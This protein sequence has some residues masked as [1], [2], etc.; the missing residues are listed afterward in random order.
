MDREE[1]LKIIERAAREGQTQL[2]LSE[3]AITSLPV[4]IGKL[5]ELTGL[6]LA[7]NQLT[8]L[9]SEIGQLTNLEV[10]SLHGNQLASVPVELAKLTKLK[11]LDLGGNRLTSIPLEIGQ[12]KNLTRLWLQDNPLESPPPEVVEQGAKAVLAYLRE[13]AEEK[14]ALNEAKML[15]VGQG[16]VGKTS[17]AKRLIEGSYNPQEMMT[18]GIKIKAWQATVKNEKIRLNVW[19][20]GGQEIMH[21]THQ[22]F[23]TKRSLYLLV[24]DSRLSE[25]ENRLEYWLRIIHSFGGESPII[26][27]GNKIDQQQLDVD[28]RGLQTKYPQIKAFVQT[29][30]KTSKGIDELKAVIAREVGALEHIHDELPLSWFVVKKN[31]EEMERNYI[32]YQ[33]YERMCLAEH[34]TDGLSQRTLIKFL[35]DLGVVLNFEDDPRLEDTNILNPE[36]VT[37]G[38]YRILNSNVLFLNKGLLERKDLNQILD[39]REYPEDKHLYIVDIMRKFE[40]CFDFEGLTDQ[41][42]VIPNLLSKE[43]PYTGDWYNA[44]AFQYHYNVLPSSIISRFIVRMHPYIYQNIYWRSGVLLAH[45]G[46]KAVVKAD[47]EDKKISIL[48][49]GHEQTRRTFL[50]TMRRNLESIHQ[51]IPRVKVKEKVPLPEHPEITVDYRHLLNLEKLGKS[52]FVPEGM[53]KEFNVK[54]LLDRVEPEQNRR[55]WKE[56]HGGEGKHEPQP[57]PLPSQPTMPRPAPAKGK[58]SFWV[59]GLFYLIVLATMILLIAVIGAKVPWYVLPTAV[60]G[61]L[62]GVTI[63]GAFDLMRRGVL[64][65]VSFLKLMVEV[66]KQMSLLRTSSLGGDAPT[67]KKKERSR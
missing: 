11:G 52:S 32:S 17:L 36:W 26:I 41:K 37:N 39:S 3:S 20:F 1:L 50:T 31:L 8:S 48:L 24:L 58:I 42:F 62:L 57:I 51:T 28:Q 5:T 40:L 35:H 47:R 64:S 61:G 38:V 2:D 59:A 33:E 4:E 29:S 25:E 7:L 54:Q 21:A 16:S 46:N 9:P 10:L 6:D 30:C 63:I 66:L 18:Q 43:E 45:Q 15:L 13:L 14:R 56:R 65:E 49:S 67:S 22:F 27:V 12:L 53:T 23:L 19:D 55:E 60:I 34:I 44:L